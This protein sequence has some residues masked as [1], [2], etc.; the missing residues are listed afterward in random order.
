MLKADLHIHSTVSDGS[1]TI[2]QIVAAAESKGIDAIAIT[3]H[4]TL[5]HL[6]QISQIFRQTRVKVLGGIEISAV[7]SVN[8]RRAHILG[9]NIK[10]PELVS[11]FTQPLLEARNRNSERQAEI[12]RSHGY[13]LDPDRLRRADGQYLYKQHIMDY[14]VT[15]GQAPEMFGDF[16]Q[17]TFKNNGICD[18]DIKYADVFAAVKTIKKAGGQAVLAHSGQQQNF[19]LIP[20]L[21]YCGL[22]GLELNH[23]ANSEADKEIIRGYAQRYGLYLTGGS[24]YH[25]RYE[26]QVFGVGDFISEESGADA[27]CSE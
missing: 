18:F 19:Y 13:E 3:E 17:A 2:A 9:Y 24:D 26:P 1:E 15:T 27:I 14:L 4:D 20:L 12:L 7:D 25:G 5:S 23:H 16:Y 22:D 10:I 8:N 11:A 21:A 6:G